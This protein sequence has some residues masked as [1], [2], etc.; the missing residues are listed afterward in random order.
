MKK[1]S[2]ATLA[3]PILILAFAC[4]GCGGDARR[5]DAGPRPGAAS[6]TMRS[7]GL[8]A[9]GEL[10]S[11]RLLAFAC[12]E[13]EPYL[14]VYEQQTDTVLLYTPDGGRHE[15]AHL[16]AASGARYGDGS[17]LLWTK[18]QDGVLLEIDGQP[19]EGCAPS[20]RQRVLTA[21]YQAGYH[22]RASGN[23][24]SWQLLVSTQSI[25]LDRQGLPA[26]NFE[27]LE[28]EDLEPGRAIRREAAGH[29][30]LI[31]VSDLICRDTMS[32]EPSPQT[33]ELALDGKTLRGCGLRLR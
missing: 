6:D 7:H 3:L 27:G 22:Y 21:A 8:H 14:A 16:P 9:E 15:L 5:Q 2:T 24:P 23:E 25:R 1:T 18:G 28:P 30:L 20:G 4:G 11:P 31:S 19:R 17:N 13:Q 12:G 26:V 33:V 29:T 10:A 32:G